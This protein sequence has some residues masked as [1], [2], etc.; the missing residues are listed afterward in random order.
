MVKS[1]QSTGHLHGKYGESVSISK[2]IGFVDDD[3]QIEND[4]F[5]TTM[6]SRTP[7]F[8]ISILIMSPACRNFG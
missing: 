6:F 2:Y 3:V 1:V 8:S 7:I 5:S 4:F